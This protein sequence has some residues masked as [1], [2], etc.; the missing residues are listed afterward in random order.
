MCERVTRDGVNEI[1]RSMTLEIEK[2]KEST[3]VCMCVYLCVKWSK[4]RLRVSTRDSMREKE[5]RKSCG[6]DRDRC[7]RQ[8]KS[9]FQNSVPPCVYISICITVNINIL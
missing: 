2:K 3:C 1:L 4:D 7:T 5:R 9:F 6:K 8:R